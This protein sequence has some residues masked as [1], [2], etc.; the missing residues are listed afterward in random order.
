MT[1]AAGFAMGAL[2]MWF[3]F[4]KHT[5]NLWIST[6]MAFFTWPAAGFT[7]LLL[8]LFPYQA[9]DQETET[10]KVHKLLPSIL[11]AVYILAVGCYLI[12]I[13]GD[14]TNMAYTLPVDKHLALLSIF[15][16]AVTAVWWASWL[17]SFPIFKI[18]WLKRQLDV[19]RLTGI[20]MLMVCYLM[21]KNMKEL[22][23]PE[24]AQ[25]FELIRAHVIFGIVRPFISVVSHANYFGAVFLLLLIFHAH[26]KQ[27]IRQLGLGFALALVGNLLLFGVKSESRI[28]IN[29]LPWLVLLCVMSVNRFKFSV[30]QFFPIVFFNFFTSKLWLKIGD[31]SG[32]YTYDD[33]TMTFPFQKFFMN[34]GPWISEQM[35]L[36]FCVGFMLALILIFLSFFSIS[37]RKNRFLITSRFNV[38]DV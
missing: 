15:A 38:E 1:D 18:E 7:G 34:L 11:A 4:S 30:W 19:S 37:L 12:Y 26:V 13:K 14:N 32:T 27:H 22:K 21:L 23:M 3:Y 10:R 36:V 24:Y 8:L 20:F 5:T 17:S 25:G 29:L 16:L 35:W 28:L 33:G 31:T 2:L 6:L 9:N